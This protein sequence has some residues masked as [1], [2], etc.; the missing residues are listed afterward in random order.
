MGGAHVDKRKGFVPD[1]VLDREDAAIEMPGA[2]QPFPAEVE[3]EEFG[4]A[5]YVQAERSGTIP[6]TSR[7]GICAERRRLD[8]HACQGGRC[9]RC[10]GPGRLQVSEGH[11]G[12]PAE[13]G[14]CGQPH[15]GSYQVSDGSMRHGRDPCRKV[16]KPAQG[17]DHRSRLDLGRSLS[18]A[19][20]R[21]DNSFGL[22]AAAKI[23][24][25]ERTIRPKHPARTSSR[26]IE[27]PRSRRCSSNAIR[28][29]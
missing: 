4:V 21:R 25:A 20:L 2:F 16:G 19:P 23:L 11:L 9:G 24:Q 1:S 3:I 18:G 27:T 12:K 8:R 26:S 17:T 5:R 10:D 6:P 7:I 13:F 15:R 14:R 29:S 28:Q 22:N